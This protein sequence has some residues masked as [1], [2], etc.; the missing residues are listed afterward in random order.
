M[1]SAPHHT[2]PS[3]P[4][5]QR[6]LL[7]FLFF[8]S[9]L[10][11]LVYQVLWV[12]DLGL[13]FGNT[14][15]A[16]ATTL[17][18]FFAGLAF[19]S[20]LWGQR[21]ATL[22][23]PLRNYA[24]LEFGIGL[25]ALLSLL[26]LPLYRLGYGPLFITF[27][28]FPA[29]LVTLKFILVAVLLLL[30]TIYMGGTLPVMGQ[31]LIRQADDLGPTASL[32]YAVNTLG[33]T[34]GALVA[35]FYLPAILGIRLSYLVT[36]AANL[37]IAAIAFWLSS[38][39]QFAPEPSSRSAPPRKQHEQP[40]PP[41]RAESLLMPLAFA[42]GFLALALEVLWT[43]MFTLV[44]Q[45]SVYSFAVILI[46][47]LFA[48]AS[49]ALLAHVLCRLH[50]ATTTVLTLLLT[51]SGG[52]VGLSPWLFH[53]LTNG[54][55]YLAAKE[56]WDSY[57][58]TV[59]L[60][61]NLVLLVPTL[62]LGTVFPYLLKVS[63]RPGV[64]A[65]QALG[66]LTA[67][68]TVG[69]ICG[70][71]LVGFFLLAAVGLW[72]SLKVM[73][74]G[75][76]LL[77]LIVASQG[78]RHRWHLQLAPVVGILLFS[79]IFDPAALPALRVN[80]QK[81]TLLQLW[82]G[83]HGTVAVVKRGNELRLK[84]DNYY[85]L[86][87]TAGKEYEQRQAQLPLA[88][89]PHPQS[90]FFLGMGTG[91]TAG[92]ALD[93]PTVQTVVICELIPEVVTAARSYFSEHSNHLFTDP[94]SRVVIADGRNYLF[95]TAETY[96]VIIS[97]LFIPW[98]AGSSSLYTQEHFATVRTRLK[99]GGLFAQWI[100]LYQLSQH[101]FA[102]IARTM[103]AVFPQV[104]LWRGDFLAD[105]PIVALIGHREQKPLDFAH[106]RTPDP[107]RAAV[108]GLLYVG[109]LHQHF[110][111]FA[112]AALNSDD[113]PVIEYLAP[114]THRRQRT[115]ETSWFASSALVAFYDQ[116][117]TATPPEQDPLLQ[118]LTPEE[119]GYVR[120]GLS[121]YKAHV[122]KDLKQPQEAQFHLRDYLARVPRVLH[123]GESR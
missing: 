34:A 47:F 64:V 93:S 42:S 71:L 41:S 75:Y 37:L 60:T 104:T 54:L 35:G 49:G 20:Y 50:V 115:G 101:E 122:Y 92:A 106:L 74:I 94:R 31:Y 1:P 29:L 110:P 17:A 63:A 105:K 33:A 14:A 88:L 84:M 28:D 113:H 65:G 11:G 79:S 103:L 120:A 81:E 59:F 70:S 111:M 44:L 95:S 53:R 22:R 30:P 32:L 76:F 36:V 48:L 66:R 96:D 85:A 102:I 68:N 46:T 5:P 107:V 90:V 119:I 43:R 116:L 12:R 108:T 51:L 123:P 38:I 56:G 78:E 9:G 121:F 118:Q 98:H 7:L 25:F 114:I 3:S 15:Y 117:F 45:N 72:T 40:T 100:P 58:G 77:A 55:K 6:L 52:F 27:G 80:P 26:L 19:G 10:T 61:A 62:C 83:K 18:V 57:L 8:I 39:A 16:T 89:H 2:H 23:N 87:G 86:G 91:I 67:M 109:T 97:D 21:A 69:A 112:E 73:A 24:L 4:L 82:E 99:P 13:V